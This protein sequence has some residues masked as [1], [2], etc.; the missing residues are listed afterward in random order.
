MVKQESN[1][2]YDCKPT[3]AQVLKAREWAAGPRDP[4]NLKNVEIAIA[5]IVNTL[6]ECESVVMT[7]CDALKRVRTTECINAEATLR[8]GCTNVMFDQIERLEGIV[9]SAKDPHQ[10]RLIIRDVRVP[11]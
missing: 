3:K 2:R 9:E 6:R 8:V 11:T 5:E 1:Q 7:V 4:G 10:P